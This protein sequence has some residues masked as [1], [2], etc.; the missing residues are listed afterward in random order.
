MAN[1][2]ILDA[3]FVELGIDASKFTRGQ[4]EATES[5]KK[6][7]EEIAKRERQRLLREGQ[8]KARNLLRIGSY[9]EAVA[10]LQELLT[11]YP[12]TPP[13]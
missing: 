2:G 13:G 10:L 3:F 8:E 4:R 7:Q 9:S 5:F 11:N 6:S 1:S 12:G